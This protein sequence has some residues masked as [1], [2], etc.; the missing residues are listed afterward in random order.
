MNKLFITGIIVLLSGGSLYADF[1]INLMAGYNYKATFGEE[2]GFHA[3]LHDPGAETGIMDRFYEDGYNRVDISGNAL[4]MTSFWGYQDASQYDPGAHTITMNSQ[5]MIPTEGQQ[6]FAD[7]NDAQPGLEIWWTGT[8]LSGERKEDTLADPHTNQQ[9]TEHA[10]WYLDFRTALRWQHVGIDQKGN[11]SGSFETTSDTYSTGGATPPTAPFDG[12][13]SG[14]N[15]SLDAIPKSRTV[16]M[17]PAGTTT[18]YYDLEADLFAL[19]LGPALTFD[20]DLGARLVLSAGATVAWTQSD[21][22]YRYS[23]YIQSGSD[24]QEEVLFG[25]YGAIDIVFIE[26]VSFGIATFQMENL[27]H[28]SNGHV[29]SMEFNDS[30][31]IRLGFAFH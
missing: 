18:A 19:D 25:Y 2:S 8:I 21:F 10:R 9:K 17:G 4:D 28:R 1:G 29:A 7:Q 11:I 26:G 20:L 23:D 27:N 12:T 13:Y 22:S 31:Y 16:S 30:Y 24:T 6:I 14:P 5:R 15:M 3:P